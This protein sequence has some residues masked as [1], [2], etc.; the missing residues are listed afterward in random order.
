MENIVFKSF[1]LMHFY[2]SMFIKN[3]L[4]ETSFAIPYRYLLYMYTE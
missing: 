1:K 3:K 4:V 2:K